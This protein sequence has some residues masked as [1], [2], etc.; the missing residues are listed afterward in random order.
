MWLCYKDVGEEKDRSDV[1]SMRAKFDGLARHVRNNH[2]NWANYVR[3]NH[4]DCLA[5]D[6]RDNH[7]RVVKA[8]SVTGDLRTFAGLHSEA[9]YVTGNR[10]R[11]D[12]VLEGLAQALRDMRDMRDDVLGEVRE[13]RAALLHPELN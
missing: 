11:V 1:L 5:R 3:D 10:D 7:A 6:V 2:V 13:M 8:N 4:V 9:N 12:Q